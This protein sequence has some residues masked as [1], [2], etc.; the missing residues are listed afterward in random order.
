[1]KRPWIN[2]WATAAALLLAWAISGEAPA[3]RAPI[4]SA[5]DCAGVIGVWSNGYHTSLSVRASLLGEGH[6]LRRL[7]PDAAYLMIGWGDLAFYRSR[8]DDILLGVQALAPGGQSGMHI[9]A[10]PGPVESWYRGKEVE[11]VALSSAGVNALSDYIKDSMAL[12][13]SGAPE[14][15]AFEQDGYFL[16]GRKDFH[17]LNVCNHWTARALRAAGVPVNVAF[18]FTGDM[19]V[20][21]IGPA[22]P[23]RCAP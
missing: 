5:D 13:A 23:D 9:L 17:A 7:Y 11:P 1:M 18:A 8:G 22:A 4:A 6:P 15:V 10:G 19:A 3:R 2:G 16:K 12:D 20:R 14:V 21:L